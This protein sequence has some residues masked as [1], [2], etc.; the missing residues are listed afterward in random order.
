MLCV[1]RLNGV[2]NL[3]G[4]LPSCLLDGIKV[5]GVFAVCAACLSVGGRSDLPDTFS[6]VPHVTA[7]SESVVISLLSD[8]KVVV[9]ACVLRQRWSGQIRRLGWR[10][11][12][13]AL[14]GL[15]SA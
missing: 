11:I 13:K 2:I 7:R 4:W 6:F 14:A 8:R 15:G 3:A 5:D 9:Q 1:V 12:Y 10:F